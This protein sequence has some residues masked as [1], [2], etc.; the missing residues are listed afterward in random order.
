LYE[1]FSN[2]TKGEKKDG[3]LHEEMSAKEKFLRLA[4]S[5]NRKTEGIFA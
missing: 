1:R 3:F 5:V 2:K 4:P